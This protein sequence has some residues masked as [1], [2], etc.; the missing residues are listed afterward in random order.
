[1]G[2]SSRTWA[3]IV[4][5][6]LAVAFVVVTAALTPWRERPPARADQ[7]AALGSLPVEH[8][9]RGKAFA[10]ARRPATYASMAVGLVAALLLGL[11]PAGARI[12]GAIGGGWFVRA[13]VGGLI[14][15]V[16]LSVVTLP[17]GAWRHA[18]SRRFGLT[19]QGWSGWAVD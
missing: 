7:L 2:V 15:V 1:A 3:V 11:P 14:L 6:A 9:A 5:V 16:L 17:F 13:V 4:F 18:I 10:A 19:T 12:V 8:V